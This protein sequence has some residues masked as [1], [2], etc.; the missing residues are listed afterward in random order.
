MRPAQITYGPISE[1][2]LGFLEENGTAIQRREKERVGMIQRLKEAQNK[3]KRCVIYTKIAKTPEPIT[4]RIRYVN[5]IVLDTFEAR[6]YIREILG[7][8][9]F[10]D[11]GYFATSHQLGPEKYLH[12]LIIWP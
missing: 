1:D 4:E 9:T 10:K 3:R 11:Y 12:S 5:K 8:E 6:Q 2:L 7:M